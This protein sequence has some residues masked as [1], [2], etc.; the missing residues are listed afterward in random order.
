MA[1][2]PMQ[3]L[4]EARAF[5]DAVCASDRRVNAATTAVCRPIIRRFTTRPQLRPGAMIDVTR[6]WRDT[7]TDDFTL[8]TQVRAHPKKGLSIAELRLAS[9]RW[10]NTEWGGAE[11][12]PGVSLVLMLLSTENDRLTFTV[13]PVANLLLHALGRR[14]QRGD[15]HDTAAILRDLRPLGAV[16]ETS[17]V[18]IPV[19]AGRWVGERVTVRD[20]VEN[21]NVPMLHV[22]T[23]LN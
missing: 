3:F 13:T 15:G 9:A 17:D 14:F 2:L 18:E 19:S 21:R 22:Q 7:V 16:I 11:S 12:A 23:F 1:S 4:G 6:A 8:D 20:D 10:K 5:R